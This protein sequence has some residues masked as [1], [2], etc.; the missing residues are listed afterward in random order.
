MNDN[1]PS[2]AAPP[3]LLEPTVRLA[4]LPL[5]TQRSD[6]M[7]VLVLSRTFV[8]V[9]HEGH[10]YRVS[11]ELE[12]HDKSADIFTTQRTFFGAPVNWFAPELDEQDGLDMLRD[13]LLRDCNT[14]MKIR[15]T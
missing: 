3:R 7:K 9:E 5:D 11:G 12:F 2:Q 13:A 6:V 10:D 1:D 8:K 15:P 4:G 14:I